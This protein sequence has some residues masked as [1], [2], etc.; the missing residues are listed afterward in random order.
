MLSKFLHTHNYQKEWTWPSQICCRFNSTKKILLHYTS[1][2]ASRWSLVSSPF[3][4]S[5]WPI[6]L[7]KSAHQWNELKCYL[8]NRKPRW[9]FRRR[10]THVYLAMLALL[11]SMILL[12]LARHLYHHFLRL[13]MTLPPFSLQVARQV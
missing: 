7:S 8:A 13:R 9:S 5:A 6:F 1:K 12:R 10:K 11:M 2:R 4:D 3:I